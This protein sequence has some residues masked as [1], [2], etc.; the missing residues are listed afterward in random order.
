MVQVLV[1][2]G[3]LKGAD[4]LRNAMVPGFAAFTMGFF[5]IGVV[6]VLH[7]GVPIALMA[8]AISYASMHGIAMYCDSTFSSSAVACNYLIVTIVSLYLVGARSLHFFSR[9]R[10]ALPGAELPNAKAKMASLLINSSRNDVVVIGL[11][12]NCASASVFG[13]KI[14]GLTTGFCV[15]QVPW[16]WMAGFFQVGV[17][18]LSYRSFDSLTATLFGFTSILKFAEGYSL[19]YQVWKPTEP[20]FPVPLFAVFA[21]LFLVL[22]VF[23]AARSLVEGLYILL[24]VAYCISV[25]CHPSGFFHGGY[26]GVNVALYVASGLMALAKLYNMK[27][28]IKIPMEKWTIKNL[29]I[30]TR[31]FKLQQEKEV[32]IP[33]HGF[34][35][36]TS[37]EV[38]GHACSVLTSFAIT[39]V[40]DPT[41]SY[42]P[43]IL[44]CILVTGGFLKLVCGSVAFS[45][46]KTLESIAFILYGVM[47]IIWGTTRYGG[48]YGSTRGFHL[49]VGIICFI[50]LN[51]IIVI[52]SLFLSKAWFVY[53]LTFELILISFLLDALGVLP[54][55]Y[56]VAVTIIFGLVSF[57]CFLSGLV[58][59]MFEEPQLPMGHPIVKLQ[60]YHGGSSK[61]THLPARRATSVKQVSGEWLN[62]LGL[63]ESAQYLGT[64]K[65]VTIRVP[66][67]AITTYLI[68][69]VG[70][71]VAM[72]ARQRQMDT[73]HRSPLCT[74]LEDQSLNALLLDLNLASNLG[75][76]RE[77][78]DV[79]DAVFKTDE[80]GKG[81]EGDAF[82]PDWD[83]SGAGV[84]SIGAI[85]I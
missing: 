63:K 84:D 12:V 50:L 79:N 24:F 58:N 68:D 67:C 4:D 23:M 66:D 22:A 32:H 3:V 45:R 41:D 1:G 7:D 26:Q 9:K 44:P 70:P 25:A 77:L 60:G 83:P 61:C 28:N 40:V 8:F 65:R 14:L 11:I 55:G 16:L 19:L 47:W 29:F 71:I 56:D 48:L 57:Y 15:G 36:Y 46:G 51:G 33:F 18:I 78:A 38:L 80:H 52:G 74:Q 13:C 34:S 75:V 17:C 35:K 37:G 5:V 62:C 27:A 59:S 43:M 20:L 54:A 82:H 72:E 21:L 76:A 39:P 64:D 73:T 30:H 85:G 53:C 81:E 31:F 10:I 2:Q 6:G 42:V 69:L 49:A